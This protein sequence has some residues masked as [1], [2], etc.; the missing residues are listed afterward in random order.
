[1]GNKTRYI[2]ICLALLLVF[3]LP[4]VTCLAAADTV[5]LLGATASSEEFISSPNNSDMACYIYFFNTH[6]FPDGSEYMVRVEGPRGYNREYSIRQA[7]SSGVSIYLIVP[8]EIGIYRLTYYVN[9]GQ[10]NMTPNSTKEIAVRYNVEYWLSSETP[11]IEDTRLEI[12]GRLTDFYGNPV[13]VRPKFSVTGAV[14]EGESLSSGGYFSIRLEKLTTAGRKALR[15]YVEDVE[16]VAWDVASNPLARLYVAPGTLVADRPQSIDVKA[17]YVNENLVRFEEEGNALLVEL[18]G[19]P[20]RVSSVG[21]PLDYDFYDDD[22]THYLRAVFNANT[23]RS[24]Q[25]IFEGSGM[26]EL[27]ALT[28]GYRYQQTVE[29]PVVSVNSNDVLGAPAYLSY[30]G[31]NKVEL[32]FVTENDRAIT[33]Y[34]MQ[35]SFPDGSSRKW[36]NSANPILRLPPFT[37]RVNGEGSLGLN[38]QLLDRRP[39][40]WSWSRTFSHRVPEVR[41]SQESLELGVQDTLYLEL[42]DELGAA[43]SNAR[44]N[45]PGVGVMNPT[46]KAGEYSITSSWNTPGFQR[47]EA[48]AANGR[49][50]AEFSSWLKVQAPFNYTISTANEALLAGEDVTLR[51]NVTDQRG[52]ALTGTGTK[53]QAYVDYN[54]TPIQATWDGT[55]YVVRVNPWTRVEITAESLDGRS[56]AKPLELEARGPQVKASLAALTSGFREN[57]ELTFS[58]PATGVPMVGTIALRG[59]NID[60]VTRNPQSNGNDNKNGS[61]FSW[62]VCARITREGGDSFLTADFLWN[63][64]SYNASI[65]IPVRNPT[66][67]TDPALFR[68]GSEM[69]VA[70][71]LLAATGTPLE[72]IM[73]R[74]STNAEENITDATGTASFRVRVTN[75]NDYT[76]FINRDDVLLNNGSVPS[77]FTHRVAV[78]RDTTPPTIRVMGTS[79]G[80]ITTTE[81]PY[82][83]QIEFSDDGELDFFFLGIVRHSLSGSSQVWQ[84]SVGL[85]LGNNDVIII[86]SDK[87]GNRSEERAQIV[88]S[89]P[90]V[91]TPVATEPPGAPG[92]PPMAPGQEEI[93]TMV[94]GSAQVWRGETLLEA[95]PL[96]PQIY[97]GR[98]MLPFRYLCQTVMG[99]KVDYEE[100][101][102]R[103]LTTV[104]GHELVMQVDNPLMTVDGVEYTLSVAPFVDGAGYTMVPLRAFEPIVTSLA[105]D[106]VAQQVTI[107]P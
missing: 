43:V 73:I 56:A 31:E 105:W 24:G 75:E 64:R 91:T 51:I 6:I 88:Y 55:A 30:A 10:Q 93:V 67:E 37:Y 85:S 58:H 95:P 84:G 104:N 21:T 25:I 80:R 40:E 61:V 62:D 19:V 20:I 81:N 83:L 2:F 69:T 107:V 38:M 82:N 8:W 28:E 98:T 35:A 22:N 11:H 13:S 99:G 94:I 27:T 63:G 103:I 79:E 47:I 1:M 87:A 106:E 53:V 49:V 54:E 7:G 60:Y 76:F 74:S 23:L 32:S 86:A 16:I 39:E 68:F 15:F 36:E 48:T 44:V 66:V 26:L 57:L 45:L 97:D 50:L 77:S 70:V 96:P 78:V 52:A 5:T 59:S 3:A 29:I 9:G 100:D 90:G 12:G 18:Y 89:L 33:Q 17:A 72:G 65:A 101:T 34:W 4:P 71:R 92:T 14:M 41:L 42:Y 46:G 102:R